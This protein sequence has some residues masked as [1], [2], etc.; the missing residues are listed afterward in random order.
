MTTRKQKQAAHAKRRAHE[1]FGLE[2]TKDK[3][4]AIIRMIQENKAQF[5][6]KQSL[7]V[8]HWVVEF[9]G[10][11]MPVVYDSKRHTL[12]TVLPAERLS[13]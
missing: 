11:K 5:V 13:E 8:S 12:A 7:R 10:V 9:E 1:R 2:L 3:R 4:K 6:R